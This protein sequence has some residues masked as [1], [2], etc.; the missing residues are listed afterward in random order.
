MQKRLLFFF[1][2][3]CGFC[4]QMMPLVEQAER[5]LGV[6]F[7]RF[8]TW[9]NEENAHALTQYDKGYCGGVPFLVNT[10]TGKWICGAVDYGTLAAFAKE[11]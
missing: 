11:E 6:T 5:E 4:H 9:H 3:E 7:E 8:E 10:K 2:R 1:G